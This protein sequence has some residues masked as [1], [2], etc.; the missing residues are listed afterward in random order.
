MQRPPGRQWGTFATNLGISLSITC[1]SILTMQHTLKALTLRSLPSW[2]RKP[3]TSAC[4]RGQ[5]WEALQHV[6]REYAV[7]RSFA[8]ARQRRHATRYLEG[9]CR[10]A[11]AVRSSPCRPRRRCR[12]AG[13]AAAPAA[14]Q[15][16]AARGACPPGAWSWRSMRRSPPVSSTTSPGSGR[17]RAT[18]LHCTQG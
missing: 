17:P 8:P 2:Q 11:Q 10:A 9:G 6:F 16:A 4:S 7:S 3:I 1:P 13:E 12:L 14:A 5:R 15:P 18:F